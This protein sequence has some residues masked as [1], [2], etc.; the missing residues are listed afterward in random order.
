M[1]RTRP[2]AYCLRL[3]EAEAEQLEAVQAA[4]QARIDALG[5]VQTVTT[6]D[7]LRTLLRAEVERLGLEVAAA[8][9]VKAPR[10]PKASAA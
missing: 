3:S 4:Y 5:Q 2:R 8:A 6:A 10:R 9:K 7:V 1:S